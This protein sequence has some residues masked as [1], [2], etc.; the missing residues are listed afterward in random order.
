MESRIN[1]IYFI[2]EFFG[3]RVYDSQSQKELYF[4][5]KITQGINEILNNLD[6]DNP[7][8]NEI[9]KFIAEKGFLSSD[10]IE[11]DNGKKAGVSSPLKISLNIT[12]KCNLKC[13]HCLSDSGDADEK[14][15]T[16]KDYYNLIDK[17]AKTGTFFI[18]IGGGEPLLR[19]DLF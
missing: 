10:I 16:T 1:P 19:D 14:E 7:G 9:K 6:N 12:K 17:M 4:D 5:K 3:S 8:L 18:T 2:N 15:L 11:I 13:R